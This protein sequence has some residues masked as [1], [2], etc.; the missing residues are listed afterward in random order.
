M[1]V[2]IT[3]ITRNDDGTVSFK[4]TDGSDDPNAQ[5]PQTTDLDKLP[6]LTYGDD[7]YQLPETTN[8]ELPLTWTSSNTDVAT[9]SDNMIHILKAGNSTITATQ[10]GNDAYYPFTKTFS[11]TIAKAQLTITVKDTTMV[12]GDEAVSNMEKTVR[13]SPSCPLPRP[14]PP[15]PANQANTPSV[16]QEPKATTT[17]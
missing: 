6:T 12:E 17:R 1:N 3:D 5:K 7:D 16:C 11:L 4:F 2:E 13:R 9:I 14:Q 10:E 8:E 15:A